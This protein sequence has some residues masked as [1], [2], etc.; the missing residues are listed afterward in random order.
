MIKWLRLKNICEEIV[1]QNITISLST[2]NDLAAVNSVVSFD[3]QQAHII[4]NGLFCKGIP[5]IV[6]AVSHELVHIVLNS[7]GHPKDFEEKWVYYE[8]KILER[9]RQ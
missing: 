6:K 8:T 2:S 9:Y 3:N 5:Q 1:E 7:A 4:L